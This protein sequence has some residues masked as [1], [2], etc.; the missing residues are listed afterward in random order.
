MQSFYT[1]SP[2]EFLNASCWCR[3]CVPSLSHNFGA[4]S[5]RTDFAKDGDRGQS[6]TRWGQA[7]HGCW[8]SQLFP[9]CLPV[10]SVGLRKG[11]GCFPRVSHLSPR[12]FALLTICFPLVSQI[13]F[14]CL[15]FVSQFCSICLPPVFHLRPIFVEPSS[16]P[17]VFQIFVICFSHLFSTLSP[18]HVQLFSTCFQVL[19]DLSSMGSLP[20]VSRC[21]LICFPLLL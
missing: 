11:S 6:H 9:S 21:V 8:V 2:K 3:T 10:F 4:A 7:L 14:M 19:L 20:L 1:Q 17:P 5:R 16:L 18:S 15:Q 12:F 13:F